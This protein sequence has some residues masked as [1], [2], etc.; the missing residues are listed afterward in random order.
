[1]GYI[2]KIGLIHGLVHRVEYSGL[3]VKH[4]IGVIRYAVRNAVDAFKAGKP[5]V[6]C[7]DPYEII[8]DFSR[9]VHNFASLSL[10]IKLYPIA[11]KN[12]VA[13]ATV[14]CYDGIYNFN[15]GWDRYMQ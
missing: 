7:A 11:S 5:P 14:I 1:M 3:F 10:L 9:A 15:K 4:D 12:S 8:K 6:I 2:F 13:N